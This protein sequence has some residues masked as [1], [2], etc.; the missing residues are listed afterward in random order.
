[1]KIQKLNFKQEAFVREYLSNGGVGSEAY[2]V[3]YDQHNASAK[4]I[5]RRSSQL[6]NHP[7]IN[8]RLADARARIADRV[9]MSVADVLSH[10]VKIATADPNELIQHRRV[11]CRYCHGVG[12]EYQWTEGEY[13][14]ACAKAIDLQ[15]E[16]PKDIG[17]YGFDIKRAPNTVC[18]ECNGE[19]EPN[20]FTGDT[21]YLSEKARLLYGGIKQTK[22]GAEVVLR[23]QDA[24][25]QSIARYLGMFKERLEISGKEG[26]PIASI[27]TVT[28]DPVEAAKIY[29]QIMKGE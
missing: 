5:A 3:A 28:T 7:I 23:N 13:T 9:E 8:K 2:K 11:N 25:L 29:Q 17:G 14:R 22:Y 26:G 20:V 4:N 1:M 21:R 19:G 12:G 15:R 27:S 18:V 6:Y 10:W 24:A 16:L